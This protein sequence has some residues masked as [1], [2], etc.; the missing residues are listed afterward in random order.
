[1][2]SGCTDGVALNNRFR[3][4][5]ESYAI[6]VS[7]SSS[8]VSLLSNILLYQPAFAAP[9]RNLGSNPNSQS[10]VFEATDTSKTVTNTLARTGSWVDVVQTAGPPRSF[11]IAKANG[12]FLL[13]L[14]SAPGAG[15]TATFVY[16]IQ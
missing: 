7:A 2:F 1:M 11:T 15:L 3:P 6:D 5:I 13:T 16:Q 9:F 14:A 8:R 4:A 10:V 12:S